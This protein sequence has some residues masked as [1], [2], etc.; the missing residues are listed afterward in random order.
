VECRKYQEQIT[1]AVDNALERIEKEGLDAHLAQCPSCM[2]EFEHEKLT[3]ILVK[4]RCQRQRA[5]EHVMSQ[6]MEQIAREAELPLE[7]RPRW[8][9][10]FVSPYLRPAIGF[11]L[12]AILVVVLLDKNNNINAPRV[13]QASLLPDNDIIRQSLENYGAVVSGK[14]KPTLASSK[15]GEM[16]NYFSGKTEFPVV[17]PTMNN[18]ELLGGVLNEFR[19]KTLAHVVYNHTTKELIYV[20]EACWKTVQGGEPLHLAKDVQD[21]LTRTGWYSI[22]A[23][24]GRTLVMWT[25]GTTLC[26]AVSML[27]AKVL[28]E[29]VIAGR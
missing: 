10:L 11:A 26:S 23:P 25:N 16:Q 27:D 12:A 8:K 21:E 29:C 6:L 1:A 20:Y 28:K 13:V 9:T 4:T 5:P 19:G 14:I 17:V 2:S 3:R 22:T 18:C 7:R 15:V 24:D